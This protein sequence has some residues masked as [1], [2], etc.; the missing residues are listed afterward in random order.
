MYSASARQNVRYFRNELDC[1]QFRNVV[2]QPSDIDNLPAYCRRSPQRWTFQGYV[3][4]RSI[5]EPVMPM[6]FTR[7]FGML[8]TMPELDVNTIKKAECRLGK[9]PGAVAA[10]VRENLRG[11]LE[12]F[13]HNENELLEDEE[14]HG[15]EDE[16]DADEV[17]TGPDFP[18][19]DITQPGQSTQED[20]FDGYGIISKISGKIPY[21][22][23]GISSM[24]LMGIDSDRL[25]E[26][27]FHKAIPL[28]LLE[29]Y[30]HSARAGGDEVGPSRRDDRVRSQGETIADEVI[31]N[32]DSDD[33]DEEYIPS[34]DDIDT[35]EHWIHEM[36]AEAGVRGISG[37]VSDGPLAI[38]T[39]VDVVYASEPPNLN[40]T[41]EETPRF[42]TTDRIDN[43]TFLSS[44]RSEQLHDKVPEQ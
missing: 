20:L 18:Q 19:T 41:P 8:Q 44:P 28:G 17:E 29:V 9:V 32:P 5:I 34:D 13:G 21:S 3:I 42:K 1:L 12:N 36:E 2:W 15:D 38:G 11:A 4:Y 24:K 10:E 40:A 31:D 25:W 16:F 35:E 23:P 22:V 39:V 26:I 33:D 27:F 30:I 7:Q 37:G 14:M 6:R 43:E